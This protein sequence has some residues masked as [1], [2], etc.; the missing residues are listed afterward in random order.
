MKRGEML[1]KLQ[2]SLE[3]LNKRKQNLETRMVQIDN[4]PDE[5]VTRN[6]Y[7]EWH[8]IYRKASYLQLRIETIK[9]KMEMLTDNDIIKAVLIHSK[10][11][12]NHLRGAN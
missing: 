3:I 2:R 4:L 7:Q 1:L 11:L 6:T 8:R 5:Q 10:G 9:S 12:F